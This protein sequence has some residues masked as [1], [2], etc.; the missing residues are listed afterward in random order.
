MK[1]RQHQLSLM[2]PAVAVD[3]EEAPRQ[4]WVHDAGQVGLAEVVAA[5]HEHVVDELWPADDEDVIGSKPKRDYVC[6]LGTAAEESQP[7]PLELIEGL[8][9]ALT[10]ADLGWRRRI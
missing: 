10:Q 7:I 5:S 9:G 8:I 4:E 3:E 6:R 1:C 2:E